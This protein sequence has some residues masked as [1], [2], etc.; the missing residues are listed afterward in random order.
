MTPCSEEPRKRVLI[1]EVSMATRE[2]CIVAK[3]R[4][5]FMAVE[6]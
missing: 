5:E 1:A 6:Y 4:G 3:E 2:G